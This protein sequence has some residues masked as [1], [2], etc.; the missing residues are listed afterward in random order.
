MHAPDRK[1]IRAFVRCMKEDGLEKFCEHISTNLEKGI[2]I[3]YHGDGIRGDYDL[4]SEEEVLKLL[5]GKL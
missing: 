3:V 1:E 4:D 2:G 5:R